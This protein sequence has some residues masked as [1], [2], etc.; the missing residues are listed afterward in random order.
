MAVADVA[1]CS[2]VA[3]GGE[4]VMTHVLL[5]II[6]G[7]IAII[8]GGWLLGRVI[9]RC[10]EAQ[11]QDIWGRFLEAAGE[12]DPDLTPAELAWRESNLQSVHEIIRLLH[13]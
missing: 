12:P 2:A 3:G 7:S 13:L 5:A 11:A 6:G 1:A 10:R 8:L 4:A 9:Q